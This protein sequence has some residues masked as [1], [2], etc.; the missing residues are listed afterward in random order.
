V[1]GDLKIVVELVNL[2]V[3]EVELLIHILDLVLVI[4]HQQVLLKVIMVVL[5]L[6]VLDQEQAEAEQ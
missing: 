3:Q 1:V 6:E 2:V 5:D 4:H